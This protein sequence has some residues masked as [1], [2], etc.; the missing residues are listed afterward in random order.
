LQPDS[1]TLGEVRDSR[2]KDYEDRKTGEDFIDTL[3]VILTGG[4]IT[5]RD[6]VLWSFTLAECAPYIEHKTRDIMFREVIL[7]LL[8]VNDKGETNK[9]KYCQACKAA[10]KNVDCEG[11]SKEIAWAQPKKE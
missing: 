10:K 7:G 11:C 9:D 4:D 6:V 3:C 8:G 2:G 1:I 5:K